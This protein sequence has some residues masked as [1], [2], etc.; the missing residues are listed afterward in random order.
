MNIYQIFFIHSSTEGCLFPY[1]DEQ[2]CCNEHRYTSTLKHDS[3]TL[4]PFSA[5]YF[6]TVVIG[7]DT[8]YTVPPHGLSPSSTP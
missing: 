5:W 4:S 7:D 6:P 8:D 3:Y 2:Q 1:L